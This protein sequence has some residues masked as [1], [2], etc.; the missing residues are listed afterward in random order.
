MSE[1][2]QLTLIWVTPILGTLFFLS[3][4]LLLDMFPPPAADLAADQVVAFYREGG[5]QLRVGAMLCVVTGGFIIPLTAVLTAQM[6]RLEEGFPV[7]AAMQLVGGALGTVIYMIPAMFWG[8]AGFTLDRAPELTL[9]M[10]EVAFL[11]LVAPW[12]FFGYQIIPIAV[13]ALKQK[14]AANTAIPRWVGYLSLWTAFITLAGPV[15]LLVKT[16]PFAWNGLLAFWMPV[17]VYFVWIIS[18]SVTLYK[19]IKAQMLVK[20]NAGS[21]S[22]AL[23]YA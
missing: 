13:V 20:Q 15:C 8:I 1:K 17:G 14:P 21:E 2:H 6:A 23:S 7:Y 19:G 9:L 5:L 12:T 3:Y 16:G 22:G 4:W 11:M 10:H 18:L